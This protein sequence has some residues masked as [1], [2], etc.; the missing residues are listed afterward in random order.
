MRYVELQVLL[1]RGDPLFLVDIREPEEYADAVTYPTFANIPMGKVFTD[2]DRLPKGRKIVVVCKTGGR[3][4]IVAEALS[5]EG[6]DV[7]VLEG[8]TE[9]IQNYES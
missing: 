8:G 6:Y 7:E 4:E 3:S 9:S 5:Q 2:K 1:E